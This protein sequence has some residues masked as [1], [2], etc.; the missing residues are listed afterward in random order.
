MGVSLPRA[1]SSPPGPLRYFSQGSILSSGEPKLNLTEEGTIDVN[2]KSTDKEQQ[3]FPQPDEVRWSL[4]SIYR[5]VAQLSTEGTEVMK[6]QTRDETELNSQADVL[7][8]VPLVA[9]TQVG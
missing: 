4:S 1:K 8:A 3:L 2:Q 9:G 5:G 7:D 6:K